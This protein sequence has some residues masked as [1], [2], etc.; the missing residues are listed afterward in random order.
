MTA[1]SSVTSE[2]GWQSFHGSGAAEAR[3]LFLPDCHLEAGWARTVGRVSEWQAHPESV[4]D[5]EF[6]GPSNR[7]LEYAISFARNT[8]FTGAFPQAPTSVTPSSEG[9]VVFEW[10][11]GG[12]VTIIEITASG[13]PEIASY[14]G[15][16]LLRH[17]I[18]TNFSPLYE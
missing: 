16:R 5:E 3:S 9:G 11:T 2:M 8:A 14:S 6:G 4:A 17:G 15:A 1:L 18:L 7:A 13:E 10:R 12:L